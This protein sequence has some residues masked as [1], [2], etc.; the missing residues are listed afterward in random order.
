MPISKETVKDK[1][2]DLNTILLNMLQ[3]GDFAKLNIQGSHNLPLGQDNDEFVKAV[4]EKYGKEKFFITYCA[5]LTCDAGP[6]AA[7]ALRQKGFKA[8]EYTGGTQ[9]WS[10][11]GFPTGGSQATSAPTANPSN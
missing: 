8:T 9:E 2:K 3:E 11:A 7:K 5:S 1:M 10:Q 4:K 6:K